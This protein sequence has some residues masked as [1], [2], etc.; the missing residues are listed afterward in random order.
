[1]HFF[2][3]GCA[4]FTKILKFLTQFFLQFSTAGM[5]FFQ[6]KDLDEHLMIARIEVSCLEEQLNQVVSPLQFIT[7]SYSNQS[8]SIQII[9]YHS[10]NYISH[11]IP[12]FFRDLQRLLYA[13]TGQHHST[14]SRSE[15]SSSKSS[16]PTDFL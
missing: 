10:N 1:M 5:L 11:Y 7:I 4:S 12:P 9:V 13:F 16:S 2:L 3:C 8:I 15:E 14:L 6:L